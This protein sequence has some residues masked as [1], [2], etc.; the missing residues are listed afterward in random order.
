MSDK[1]GVGPRTFSQVFAEHDPSKHVFESISSAEHLRGDDTGTRLYT[2][3]AFSIS[4]RGDASKIARDQKW[5]QGSAIVRQSITDEYGPGVGQAVFQKIS[6]E[7]GRDL[8]QAVLRGDLPRI[9]YRNQRGEA[10]L[11]TGAGWSQHAFQGHSER[12]SG[13]SKGS[14]WSLRDRRLEA[15][16]SAPA[17][18]IGN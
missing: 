3:S 8:S 4:G 18:R 11:D 5:A 9:R 10:W 6:A 17:Q 2:H 16:W 7:T 14:L 13:R 1:V 15:V 12:Q